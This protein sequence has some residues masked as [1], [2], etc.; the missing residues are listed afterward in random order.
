MQEGLCLLGTQKFME[1]LPPSLDQDFVLAGNVAAGKH[2]PDSGQRERPGF[3]PA[4]VEGIL[5]RL[6]HFSKT[7]RKMDE[8]L[9]LR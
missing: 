1:R 3:L 8:P 2:A 4:P 7:G 9:S 5:L 6:A